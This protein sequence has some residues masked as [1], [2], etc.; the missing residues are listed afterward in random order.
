MTSVYFKLASHCNSPTFREKHNDLDG[1]E[2]LPRV[3]EKFRFSYDPM[4]YKVFDIMHEAG[5]DH[6]DL[7]HKVTITLIC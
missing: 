4:V 2:V 7:M 6:G 1:F 3:G 5:Y